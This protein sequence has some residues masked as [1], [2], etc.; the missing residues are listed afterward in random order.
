MTVVRR[1]ETGIIANKPRIMQVRD[2]DRR[3]TESPLQSQNRRHDENTRRNNSLTANTFDDHFGAQRSCNR[4][5]FGRWIGMG[6][7]A[8][9]CAAR[10]DRI[11]RN[12]LHNCRQ[13]FAKGPFDDGTSK[14]RMPDTRTDA[15][16]VAID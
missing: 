7:A 10:A 14:C 3:K 4:T 13:Q 15:Q 9:E 1:D 12:V 6:N 11:M 5:P 2:F 16:S 8:A